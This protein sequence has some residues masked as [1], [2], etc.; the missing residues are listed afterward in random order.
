[1]DYTLAILE[2]I[3]AIGL[4]A[5]AKISER[6]A[7]NK[8]KLL[9]VGPVIIAVL[10]VAFVGWDWLY[11]GVY[12]AA[13]I[14]MAELLVD[15]K[16]IRKAM[17]VA[18]ACII[19]VTMI[20]CAISPAYH[21]QDFAA[22]FDKAFDI[23]KEHY[24]LD[25]EKGIDWDELYDEYKPVFA[26][27]T[28]NSDAILNYNTWQ[29]F[30][31][32][33]YDGHVSY[34]INN[35]GIAVQAMCEDYGNDY[36]LSLLRAADGRYVAVNVEG[37][38]NCY[39]VFDNIK[40]FEELKYYIKDDAEANKLTL[41]NAGVKNGTV[42]TA[43]NGKPIDEHMEDVKGKLPPQIFQTPD[44]DNE[45]F[46]R[47]LYAAGGS[48][49]AVSISYLDDE[50][51]EKTV[52][53]PALGAYLGRLYETINILD[54]GINIT[55]LEWQDI[56]EDTAIIRISEMAYDQASYSG[57]DYS[58][59][60]DEVRS[61]LSEEKARGV[62]NIIFDL[63]QNG[64]GSPFMVTGVASLFAPEGEHIY[65]Y[66]SIINEKTA[67]YERNGDGKY[68]V[69]EALSYDG[70]DLFADGNIIILVNAETVSAG[71]DM[72]NL[73]SEYP[74]VTIMGFTKSNCSCQA[75]TSVSLNG[76]SFTFSAVPA[77][78]AEGTPMIDSGV[79]HVGK[80]PIDVIVPFDEKA[81]TAIFESGE[82]YL[83]DYA[84]KYG[85]FKKNIASK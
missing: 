56:N 46:Y 55:N 42:I 37:Y 23:L 79:D 29:R 6:Y 1:M 27:A 63:R 84:V 41:K 76:A 47:P 85:K 20:L 21:K 35:G 10:L 39:S 32:E 13:F 43:W 15:K 4:I 78:D 26:E 54:K 52:T 34:V 82:D 2:L 69:G 7:S 51:N 75:V 19:V 25:K 5:T 57:S 71:D 73:M 62:K 31:R 53:A 68:P 12:V 30:T 66:C 72:T 28:K 50:G 11:T 64:G 36:G 18:S 40:D 8:W 70:E 48:E 45:E 38:D 65:S 59:M 22:D 60:T 33:F 83:L 58:K 74:N 14:M 81:V 67:S 9:N 24:I 16:A 17:S 49:D 80:V 61:K 44:R 77:V 3:F